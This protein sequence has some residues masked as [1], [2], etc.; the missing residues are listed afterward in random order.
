MEIYP[1][2]DI[3]T[4]ER[5]HWSFIEWRLIHPQWRTI[6]SRLNWTFSL[7]SHYQSRLPITLF[8][9]WL[10]E[11]IILSLLSLL[12]TYIIRCISFTCHPSHPVPSPP[13]SLPLTFS[14]SFQRRRR[15][16]RRQSSRQGLVPTDQKTVLVTV[17]HEW[18]PSPLLRRL[19]CRQWT[20]HFRAWLTLVA[21]TTTRNGFLV[22]RANSQVFLPIQRERE[23]ETRKCFFI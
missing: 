21:A 19:H 5:H 14:F 23:R 13:L 17:A 7:S 16:R 11:L 12:V 9:L 2:R 1:G 20:C 3:Q 8:L 15:R 6:T 10:I 4:L 18:P 22:A